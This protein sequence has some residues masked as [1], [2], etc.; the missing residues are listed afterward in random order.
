MASL[1][2]FTLGVSSARSIAASAE[3][4]EAAGW[5]GLSV[6]DSQNLAGDAWVALSIAAFL[7]LMLGFIVL[8]PIMV[9]SIYASYKDI[10]PAETATPPAPNP[11]IS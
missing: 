2:L 9:C 11:L 7:P 4:A 10:F 3:R 1:E 8:L 5:H 6:V